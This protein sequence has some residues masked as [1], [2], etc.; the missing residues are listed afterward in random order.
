MGLHTMQNTH[1]RIYTKE[2]GIVHDAEYT[3][4]GIHMKCEG[5]T[6]RGEFRIGSVN[7]E[8]IAYKRDYA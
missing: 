6:S 8:E 5:I 7:P 1:G 4:S 3:R 2:N